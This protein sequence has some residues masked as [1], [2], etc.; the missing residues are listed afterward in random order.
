MIISSPYKIDLILIEL[1]TFGYNLILL[2]FL[3]VFLLLTIKIIRNNLV[4]AANKITDF[5]EIIQV[6]YVFIFLNII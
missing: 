4:I 3:N 5:G 1:F 2:I 6:L